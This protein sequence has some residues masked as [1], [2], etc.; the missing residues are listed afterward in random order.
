MHYIACFGDSLIQGFP[1]GPDCSWCATAEENSNFRLLNY[2][3]CGECCN[4]IFHRLISTPLSE[5]VIGIIFLGGA[6]DM[7][8][9]I[10]PD[11]SVNFIKQSAKWSN[12]H[13]LLFAVVLPLISND[14][15]LNQKLLTLS[16]LIKKELPDV[17]QI[18]LQDGIGYGSDEL[19][20]A[21]LD[22]VHPTVS[23]YKKMGAV[24]RS[25]ITQWLK[26]HP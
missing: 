16:E 13:K 22:G 20:S 19:S 14:L 8:L 9:G 12:E 7:L 15:E 17:F 2:G 26:Q 10:N 1:F 25:Q 6:N 21:Y 24:A 18:D 23:T 5:K 3:V 11:Q 4:D